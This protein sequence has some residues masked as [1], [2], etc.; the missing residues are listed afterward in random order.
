M[1]H[2]LRFDWRMKALEW[3]CLGLI[4]CT[5]I[6]I[7]SIVVYLSWIKCSKDL[8]HVF[9]QHT[10]SPYWCAHSVASISKEPEMENCVRFY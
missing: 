5:H 8:E 9:S 1:D 4:K 7:A 6:R 3:N 2:F 10:N